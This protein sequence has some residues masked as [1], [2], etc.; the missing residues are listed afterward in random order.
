MVIFRE[1]MRK[2]FILKGGRIR[3]GCTYKNSLSLREE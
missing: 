3:V 2:L 1:K